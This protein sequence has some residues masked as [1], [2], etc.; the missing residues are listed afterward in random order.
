[1]SCGRATSRRGGPAMQMANPTPRCMRPTRLPPGA[2][3]Q[4]DC[5][6]VHVHDLCCMHVCTAQMRGD[7]SALACRRDITFAAVGRSIV[8]CK[9]V[10][11]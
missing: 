4:P 3:G 8:E 10:H 5:P 1:M 2:C 7:I 6:P 9:R 11:R